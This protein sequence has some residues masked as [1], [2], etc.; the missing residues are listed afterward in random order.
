MAEMVEFF[1]DN[2]NVGDLQFDP[3]IYSGRC[4]TTGCQGPTDEEY[5]REYIRAYETARRR[6]RMLGFSC[7]SFTALKSF[8]CCAVSDGFAV[9][10]EGYVTSCFEACGPD[11]PHAD[12]FLYGK[13][14]AR[15]GRF[16]LDLEKQ[17]QLQ[18]R[19]TD[20]MPYCEDCF[21]KY[22]CAGDC[23]IHSLKMGHGLERGTRCGITQAIAKHRL[24]TVV[25]KSQPVAT[26][27]SREE[28]CHGR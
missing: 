28:T 5:V 20:N 22:M 24:A 18:T 11:R 13:Y 3:L 17:R 27:P 2:F 6:N 8:Y 15:Q 25:R 14:D 16:D 4:H 26:V 7:L 9:T 19:N 21:C 1:D 10:H 12:T 23:P